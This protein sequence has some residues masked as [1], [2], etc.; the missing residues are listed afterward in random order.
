[1]DRIITATDITTGDLVNLQLDGSSFREVLSVELYGATEDSPAQVE[2]RVASP[3]GGS[4]V[5]AFP[6]EMQLTVR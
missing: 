1:M 4:F 3:L 5:T 6:A 2:V